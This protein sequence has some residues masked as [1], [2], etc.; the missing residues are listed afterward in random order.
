MFWF[1]VFLALLLGIPLCALF[2]QFLGG[3]VDRMRYPCPGRMVEVDGYRLHMK[4]AGHTGPVVV[5]EAGIAA[6]SLSWGL[7]EPHVA[8][9]A[10]VVTYDRDGLGWSEHSERPADIRRL[11]ADL[12]T[13]L[14]SSGLFGPYL[15]VGHSFGG[16]MG[17]Y[18]ACR[19]PM[20]VAGVVAADP[21]VPGEWKDPS[22]QQSLMLLRGV[23]LSRRGAVLARL[24]IVRLALD[25]L[26]LGARRLPKL[27]SRVSSGRGVT[28][29]ERIAGEVRKLPREVWPLVKAHWS[30]PKSFRAMADHLAA[31]PANCAAT[32]AALHPVDIP[33]VVKGLST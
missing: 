31:L 26:M 14:E 19:W 4:V 32:A 8:Q 22:P 5:L 6:T 9:F 30:K 25:L 24:G 7:V 16:M 2:Y 33:I 15:L 18:A 29:T 27:I 21:L 1:W 28:E 23:H 13:A 11:T 10:R 20:K 17:V 12:F 3:V